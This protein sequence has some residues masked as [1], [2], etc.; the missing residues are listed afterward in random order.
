MDLEDINDNLNED[1]ENEEETLNV[2]P[3]V[4]EL[5]VVVEPTEEIN[6]EVGGE[7]I[8]TGN[9]RE[10]SHKPQIND[11]ELFDNKSLE[12]LGIQ[13]AE[14]GKGLSTNDYTNEEKSKLEG[15]ES[16]AEVNIVENVVVNGVTATVSGKT[17]SVNIETGAIDTISVNGTPQTI[18]E[19]KNV[20]ITVPTNNNQLTNGAGYITNTAN[21]LINY[22][23]KT[24]TGSLIDLSINT[25]NYVVTLNLKD[26]D[27]NI[28]S[29][30][31]IDLPLESVV[32][33]GRYDNETKKVILTLEN[34]SE[35]D[36]SVSDLTSGLQSEITNNN[37]LASDLVDDTNSGNKFVTTSEK[38][39]WNNKSDFSG[40][41][42][43]LTDKPTIPI[44][45]QTYNGA[46]ANAQSG[47]AIDGAGFLK[48]KGNITSSTNLNKLAMGI[49]II[50]SVTHSGFPT[51]DAYY[52]VLIQ[53]G[54]DY[55]PQ[56]FI[57]GIAGECEMYYRR[58]LVGS[59]AY[60]SWSKVA[61]KVSD[62]TNDSGFITGINSTD[63]TT[64]LGY[65]PY[66]STNPSGYQTAS[67]VST[68]LGNETKWAWYGTS[69]TG[70]STQAKV[71]T[72]TGFKLTTGAVIFVKFSN[73]QTYN[74][75][76]TLNVNGTGAKTVQYKGG[77]SGIRYMWSAGEVVGFVYD[78]TYWV[79]IEKA[80]AT[81]TYYGVTK[82][83]T[84]GTSSSDTL[85]LSPAPLYNIMNNIVAGLPVYSSS[86]IYSIGDRVRY[87]TSWYECNINMSE[88]ESWTADHWTKIDNL[89][90]L[91][92]SKVN[93]SSFNYDDSSETLTITVS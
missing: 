85:A 73:G 41:Y 27:G 52:G 28:I 40:S 63:V 12:D 80:L 48:N 26:Q 4:E 56:L 87:G 75:A 43:D 17:A 50:D 8:P 74:G 25:Q 92:D 82:L 69:S 1:V 18:D 88:G 84:S 30:D 71:V 89:L 14:E 49:Y 2:N 61:Q 54:G 67:D 57:A 76:P 9:Y 86:T 16:G 35:I 7:V 66:D 33:S 11:V 83:S 77:T 34:G 64:A 42:N 68:T 72:C 29:S 23:L 47:V 51:N 31:Y 15:I 91:T 90:T 70:A 46:S 55:K 24:A 62:L 6:V 13:P 10:L 36:F 93:K 58:Y 20:D 78:G 22:T 59:S 21:D 45:D 60:T 5:H 37:K 19:N 3:N 53:Y 44:V 38:Q 32:V 39:T 81:T 65:T 79:A